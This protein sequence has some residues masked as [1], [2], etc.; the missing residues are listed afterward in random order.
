M[1]IAR[2]KEQI[3]QQLLE[4]RRKMPRRVFLR[5]SAAICEQLQ[6]LPQYAGSRMIHCYISLNE[7]RE[8]NTR[9]LI[10][11]ML[12]SGKRVVVPVTQM[13]T[14][15]LRHVEISSFD[16]LE[17]NRWGVL[18]PHRGRDIAVGKL[19]LVIVPMVGGDLEKNRIGYGKGFYD[20]F[21]QHAECDTIG[22]LFEC[23]LLEAIPTEPFDVPLSQCI[24]EDRI[25]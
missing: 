12:D 3:R 10:K 15:T 18:E 5:K 19:D 8:V 20:R 1:S 16:D 17:E 14:G 11:S 7:R 9:P 6:T 23:C 22:L 13:K 2:E 25:L 24:T 21:L 4:R